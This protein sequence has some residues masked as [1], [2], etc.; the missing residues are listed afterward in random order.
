VRKIRSTTGFNIILNKAVAGGGPR[1]DGRPGCMIAIRRGANMV[2][3]ELLEH[4]YLRSFVDA[5]AVTLSAVDEPRSSISKF[6]REQ[7]PAPTLISADPKP[8]TLKA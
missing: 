2:P 7:S 8:E 4:H 1:P 6:I 3:E 5:G